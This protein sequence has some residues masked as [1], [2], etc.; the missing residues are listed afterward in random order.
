MAMSAD[1][2]NIPSADILIVEDEALV[3]LMMEEILTGAGYRVCGIAESP[4]AAR[5][6]AAKHAP[7]HAVIDV[8][9]ARG[10]DGIALAAALAASSTIGI[11]FATGNPGEVRQRAAAGHGCLAKPF[12]PDCLIAAIQAVQ[13]GRASTANILGFFALPVQGER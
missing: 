8:R 1:P 4:P 2:A 7:S 6:L 12:E 9:L 13:H 11:L 5:R 10:G 3:A